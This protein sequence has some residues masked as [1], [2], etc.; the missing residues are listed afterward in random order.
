[1]ALHLLTGDGEQ[2]YLP[3]QMPSDSYKTFRISVRPARVACF[4]DVNDQNWQAAA[5]NIIEG[6]SRVWGGAYFMI[7]PTDGQTISD[8]FWRILLSYDPDYLWASPKIPEAPRGSYV[9]LSDDLQRELKLRLAPFYYEDRVIDGF[10]RTNLEP[11]YPYTD[12]LTILPHCEHPPVMGEVSNPDG[13]MPLWTASM[14]GL[15]SSSYKE[16]LSRVG[17]TSRVIDY[18]N[19][20]PELF[21]LVSKS[22]RGEL[23]FDDAGFPFAFSLAQLGFFRSLKFPYHNEATLVVVGETVEDFCLYYCLVRLRRKVMWLLPSWLPAGDADDYAVWSTQTNIGCFAQSLS[24]LTEEGGY[25]SNVVLLSNSLGAEELAAVKNTLDLAWHNLPIED[26]L[27]VGDTP[28]PDG[29]NSAPTLATSL[30]WLLRYPQRVYESRNAGKIVSRHF[31][32]E[33]MAG[34]FEPPLP[35]NFSYVHPYDHRW[36]TEFSITNNHLPRHPSLGENVVQ[37]SFLRTQGARVGR[38][39]IAFFCP[40][41]GYVGGEI[42]ESVIRPAVHLPN[43]FSIFQRLM[44][45]L[46]YDCQISDKGRF[47]FDTIIKFGSITSL[48]H[49]LTSDGKRAVL[50]KYLDNK[51]PGPEVKDEGLVL[52]TDRRRYLDM[53]AVAKIMRGGEKAAAD[54]VDTLIGKA[55]LHRGLILK[56]EFCRSTDWFSVAE[57]TNE[58]RCRRCGRAQIYRQFHAL[59]RP[60]PVWYYKIDEMVFKGLSNGMA[61]P[62]L[63]LHQFERRA[64]SFLYSPDIELLD[65]ANGA[66]L[67]ELDICCIPDGELT[68]GEAKRANRLGR[69]AREEREEI[70]KYFDLAQRVGATQVVF[71]TYDLRWRD[72]TA[73]MITERFSGALT[74]VI[75][76]AR[77]DLIKLY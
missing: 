60:E 50:E 44:K 12:L 46:N 74:K 45:G 8:A 36:I 25:E 48:A 32:G 29:Q 55:V 3:Q 63:A 68:I 7:V 61:V 30:E 72:E 77:D 23:T 67:L 62:L 41:S 13:V 53:A 5:L 65:P 34:L 33:D 17:I 22:I 56:C 39:G 76:W 20:R 14:T 10:A 73:R 59:S 54:L 9:V 47:T 1:M 64:D 40:H 37:H 51:R 70:N 4:I 38:E 24:N 69:T 6:F 43:C 57:L 2:L 26:G 19:G 28:T 21:E 15:V 49:F 42:E 75:L 27:P 52:Q 66:Q 58:F 35:R 71:A 16:A 11:K 18:S 31:I